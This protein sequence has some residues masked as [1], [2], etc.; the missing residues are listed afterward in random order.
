MLIVSLLE[1][2]ADPNEGIEKF[3]P[4]FHFTPGT[5]AL[6]I[7]A[8]LGNNEGIRLLL[9]RGA[10]VQA[11]DNYDAT[12]L[13]WAALGSN[14]EGIQVLCAADASCLGILGNNFSFSGTILPKKQQKL[15]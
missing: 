10:D 15:Y 9:E 2:G 7:S 4:I 13:H 12:P 14:V 11:K 1:Q 6:H 3:E 8:F 5:R